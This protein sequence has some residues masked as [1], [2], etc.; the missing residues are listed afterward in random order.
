M[1][2]YIDESGTFAGAGQA[3][4]PSVIGALVV[5]DYRHES[6]MRQFRR[7]RCSLPK[8]GGQVKGRL[9]NEEQV[10]RVVTLL[11]RSGCL[12]FVQLVELGLHTV[13]GLERHRAG[14]AEG[15]LINLTDAHHA[16]LWAE[17]RTLKTR[18]ERLPLQ[19]H[20][21]AV[22]LNQLLATVLSGATTYFAQRYPRKLGRFEWVLDAKGDNDKLTEWEDWWKTVFLPFMQ[23]TSLRRPAWKLTGADYSHFKRFEMKIPD[24]L[25][26]R[27][28]DATDQ[29]SGIDLRMVF[30][31]NLRITNEG[32]EGLE[33]ADIVTNGV[34][35]AFK[36]TL[37]EAGCTP[38]RTLM[39]HRRNQYIN[40]IDLEGTQQGS[41][42]LPQYRRVFDVFRTGGRDMLV[43]LAQR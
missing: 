2:T 11:R 15:M 37:A 32:E 13:A 27:L 39:I 24:Y 1:R 3:L 20:V 36:S 28:S 31:E 41:D 9:L 29:I 38:I 26:G 7:L 21:Q 14:S 22:V 42:Y 40:V 16:N 4:T 18:L 6:L 43:L 25:L 23:S 19:L 30:R 10:A 12:F 8:D 33:L 5:P 17:S 35:R 34:R